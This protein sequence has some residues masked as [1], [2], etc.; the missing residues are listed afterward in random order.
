MTHPIKYGLFVIMTIFM[1]VTFALIRGDLTRRRIMVSARLCL[2]VRLSML[3]LSSALMAMYIANTEPSYLRTSLAVC[4]TYIVPGYAL[5]ELMGLP[6]RDLDPLEKLCFSFSYSFISSFFLSLILAPLEPWTT[7]LICAVLFFF[8]AL[9]LNIKALNGLRKKLRKRTEVISADLGELA[10]LTTSLF[11]FIFMVA[12]CYPAM[13]NLLDLDI[14]EMARCVGIWLRTPDLLATVYPGF[15]LSEAIAFVLSGASVEIFQ[16][17]IELLNIF[18][19]FSFFLVAKAI[20]RYSDRRLPALATLLFTFF[21]GLGWLYLF[22]KGLTYDGTHQELMRLAVQKT[23][24]DIRHGGAVDFF[25]WYRPRS[26]ALILLLMLL[27]SVLTRTRRKPWRYRL[28]LALLSTSL[29]I[30]HFVEYL[31]FSASLLIPVMFRVAE[32]LKLKEAIEGLLCSW[33]FIGLVYGISQVYGLINLMSMIPI[34]LMVILT[35][36]YLGALMVLRLW[37]LRLT[38]SERYIRALCKALVP[39]TIFLYLSATLAW[40]DQVQEFTIASVRAVGFLPWFFYPVLLG[41]ITPMAVIGL[42][43]VTDRRIRLTHDA[44]SLLTSLTI[45]SLVMGK[46]VAFFNMAFFYTGYMEWRFLKYVF[47]VLCPLAAPCLIRM[48]SWAKHKRGELILSGS[49]TLLIL[50]GSLSV[51]YTVEKWVME[52]EVKEIQSEEEEALNYLRSLTN[53]MRVSKVLT[54][55]PA[56][57]YVVEKANPTFVVEHQARAIWMSSTPELALS[58]LLDGRLRSGDKYIIYMHDRDWATA[59]LSYEEGFLFSHLLQLAYEAFE[60]QKVSV[61]LIP[62]FFP[63]REEASAVLVV[64]EDVPLAFMSYDMLSFGLFDY[65]TALEFDP[66]ILNADFIILPLDRLPDMLHYVDYLRWIKEGRTVLVVGTGKK[67]PLSELFMV[68]NLHIRVKESNATLDIPGIGTADHYATYNSD[69]TFDVV[70]LLEETEPLVISDDNQTEFWTPAAWGEGTIGV[71]VLSDESDFKVHGQNALKIEVGSGDKAQWALIHRYNPPANWTDYDFISLYWYGRGDWCSYAVRIEAPDKEN[72][73]WFA[74]ADSW[75]GWRKVI[76]PLRGPDGEYR[77]NGIVVAKVTRGEPDLSNV[78]RIDIRLDGGNI[79]LSGIWYLDRVTLDVGRWIDIQVKITRAP[80][81][82]VYIFNGEAYELVCHLIDNST[83]DVPSEYVVFF[84]GSNATLLYGHETKVMMIISE[85]KPDASWTIRISVKIPPSS[86]E[87]ISRMGI[88]LE[89]AERFK[90]NRIV[91]LGEYIKLPKPVNCSSFLYNENVEVLAF[92]EGE[93]GR[94]PLLMRNVLGHGTIYYL[95]IQPIAETL[96]AGF[97]DISIFKLIWPVL[98]LTGIKRATWMEKAV[99]PS[100]LIFER[101]EAQ[102]RIV[103][104]HHSV[105]ILSEETLMNITLGEGS[106]ITDVLSFHIRANE[107]TLQ[108]PNAS[109]IGLGFYSILQVKELMVTSGGDVTLFLT[110]KN[111]TRRRMELQGSLNL[112]ICGQSLR[113][114]LRKPRIEISGE[115]FLKRTYACS[116]FKAR[117]RGVIEGFLR[118]EM[119]GDILQ[120]VW[121]DVKIRGNITI[122][123]LIGGKMSLVK[124]NYRGDA[125]IIPPLLKW[126]E[127]NSLTKAWLWLLIAGGLTFIFYSFPI[128]L[129]NGWSKRVYLKRILEYELEGFS[130]EL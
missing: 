26:T 71:P 20:F 101:G 107:L 125:K 128:F 56:S 1:S 48:A 13:M 51:Y 25:L 82:N 113:I 28:N 27:Y 130:R 95:N 8:L 65:T 63:P 10:A 67:S 110:F 93:S 38:L 54:V 50:A 123:F 79:N 76:L 62:Q 29:F 120:V 49:L 37:K 44:L 5:T 118:G 66:D 81:V 7:G 103:V 72:R 11:F 18:L 78:T 53:S 105:A 61:Y 24:M 41:L 106:E 121:N 94:T 22:L 70:N 21:A 34:S 92:Y 57:L 31:L 86:G 30:T 17:I 96:E 85:R 74:F 45:S 100:Y 104:K 39:I 127:W 90:A 112:H 87:A 115:I 124:I 60:N 32:E 119:S 117:V 59:Q 69:V 3:V 47:V 89:T 55:S 129:K 111:G 6:T 68:E 80:W 46:F 84:D 122:H 43:I 99:D 77:I 98:R 83:L 14:F 19:I 73:L 12:Y 23:Y 75:V 42:N 88:K 91:Y 40:L 15:I 108:T 97:G 126:N 36:L 116:S 102:G 109:M 9:V 58:I 35:I 16:S 114:V 2:I 4:V 52:V 64:P 33:L